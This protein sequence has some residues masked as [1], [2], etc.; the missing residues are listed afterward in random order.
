MYILQITNKIPYPPIDGG[1]IAIMDM[2][3]NF[4]EEG[5]LV[6]ILAINTPK[7]FFDPEKIPKEV[8]GDVKIKAVFINNPIGVLSILKNFFFSNLPYT[9]ERFISKSFSDAIIRELKDIKWDIIQIEGL[10]LTSYI[11]LIRSNS[12][13]LITFRAHN[14]EHE[15]WKRIALQEKNIVKRYYYNNLVKRIVDFKKSILNSYDVLIPITSRDFEHFKLF[16]NTKP[17][18]VATAGINEIQEFSKNEDIELDDIFYIGALDWMPNQE[19]LLWFVKEVWPI[20]FTNFSNLKFHVA[21]RNCPKWLKSK[22]IKENGICFHGEVPSAFEFV[23]NYGIMVVPLISGSGI[24]I[25]IL[26]GMQCQKP[27]VTT[28][29]GAEGIEVINDFNILIANNAIEFQNKITSLLNNKELK[30]S[31]GTNASIFVKQSYNNNRIIKQL[32]LFYY[33]IINKN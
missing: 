15:I 6:T 32:L 1:A 17:V 2:A 23:K 22:L 20:I 10:Y 21:G 28:N 4:S 7:H 9:L 8:I 14:I 30:N 16:G 11:P 3:R 19:G 33:S 5:H 29:I 27:I 31:I 13:A 12:S 26:Q 25:K 18:F 24:R